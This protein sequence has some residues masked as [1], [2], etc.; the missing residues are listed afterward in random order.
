VFG[1]RDG[2]P[3]EVA[4]ELYRALPHA[5]LWIVP[6]QAHFPFGPD[7]GGSG[8]A[9]AELP[10]VLKAFFSGRPRAGSR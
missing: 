6:G 9:A 10:A 2:H 5:Q 1:D 8:S 7:W 3:V 4:V